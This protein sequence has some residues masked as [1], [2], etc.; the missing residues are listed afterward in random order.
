MTRFGREAGAAGVLNTNWGDCAHINLPANSYHGLAFGAAH[1]WNGKAED[2]INA[3]TVDN[4][5]VDTD[6][7]DSRFSLLQW[8]IKGGCLGKLLRE[9]GGL[10]SYH[11]GN[12]YAWVI[13]KQCLW[14]KE[15]DV[16]TADP[17]TLSAKAARAAEIGKELSQMSGYTLYA[18]VM[19]DE[20]GVVMPYGK[21]NEFLEYIWSAEA[22]A[23]LISLLIAKKKY[24]YNQQIDTVPVEPS[25]LINNGK[26]LL[27]RFKDLWLDNARASELL[28]VVLTFEAVFDRVSKWGRGGDGVNLSEP[29]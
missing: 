4:D 3:D 14:Y 10:S 26:N 13:D 28:D 8:G 20:E 16:K 17:Q 19:A 9:L 11:F 27:K 5:N 23:W 12:L 2:G 25:E 24:E 7:F 18:L 15:E 21:Y 22:T 29:S 1:S 6:D